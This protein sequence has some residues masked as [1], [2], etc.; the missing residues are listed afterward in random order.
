L[1]QVLY[2][3]RSE[4]MLMEQISCNMLFRWFVGL[5]MDGTVG[6]ARQRDSRDRS[7]LQPSRLSDDAHLPSAIHNSTPQLH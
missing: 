7:H 2:S 3:I 5:P 1:L 4:R 6:V